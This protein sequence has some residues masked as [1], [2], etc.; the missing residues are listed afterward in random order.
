MCKVSFC[1]IGHLFSRAPFRNFLW[2]YSRK[3]ITSKTLEKCKKKKRMQ[4]T[5][6]FSGPRVLSTEH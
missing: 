6:N 4:Y 1:E 5:L 3:L 2:C